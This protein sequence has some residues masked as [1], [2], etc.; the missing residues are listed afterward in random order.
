VN[1]A[2]PAWQYSIIE[3]RAGRPTHTCRKHTNTTGETNAVSDPTHMDTPNKISVIPKYIGLLVTRKTPEV[4][5][6]WFSVKWR[7]GAPR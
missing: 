5:M 2:Q 7:V 4:I 3:S 1:I 6:Y